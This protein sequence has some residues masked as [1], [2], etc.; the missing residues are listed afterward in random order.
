MNIL[1][2]SIGLVGLTSSLTGL[3]ALTT[4][5]LQAYAANENLVSSLDALVAK[6]I[7][8]N[9]EME[10]SEATHPARKRSQ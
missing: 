1:N 9:K 5:A 4:S 6:Q 8:V 3:N 2:I 10:V 7:A